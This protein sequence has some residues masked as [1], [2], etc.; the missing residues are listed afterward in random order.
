MASGLAGVSAISITAY[1]YYPFVLGFVAV[2]SILFR[3]P[4]KFN[5]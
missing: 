5:P 4:K 3:F 1:L 2:L